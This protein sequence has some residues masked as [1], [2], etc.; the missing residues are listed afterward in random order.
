[1]KKKRLIYSLLGCAECFTLLFL[2]AYAAICLKEAGQIFWPIGALLFIIAVIGVLWGVLYYHWYVAPLRELQDI[3][4]DM[5]DPS[6]GRRQ[7]S[8]E[9]IADLLEMSRSVQ[10]QHEQVQNQL[11][12]SEQRYHLMA[13]LSDDV[14]FEFDL[15]NDT[16]CD[17]S[18]WSTLASGEQ[19][20]QGSI[21]KEVIHP[22]DAAVFFDFF[23]G[24][25][26]VGELK[27]IQL[28]IY[29]R[30]RETYEWMQIRGIVLA[31][32]DGNPGKI[33]GRRLN[34]DK[35]KRETDGLREMA[36]RDSST[37]LYNKLTAETRI[38][39][40]LN[41]EPE[42][43]C[44]LLLIDIDHFK[45]VNDTLGHQV[46]DE[47]IQ[48]IAQKLDT[49]FRKDDIIGR[50]GGDEY[51]VLLKGRTIF[52]RD[53]ICNCCKRIINV[54][55]HAEVGKKYDYPLSCSIGIALYPENGTEFETLFHMA[56]KA[57]Y[58]A[59]KLGRNRFEFY[60]EDQNFT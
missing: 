7:R 26:T 28:R 33:L 55:H 30:V 15:Q 59:K 3:F 20:V 16:I 6:G 43:S 57:L 1:M 29:S 44:V 53:G 39:Q 32:K 9:L 2:C 25:Q 45:K 46:G 8:P 22:D 58:S 21:S 40:V 52:P 36:Q 18:N 17:S 23:R 37:G 35:L 10:K 5:V 54:F 27:E 11:R 31:D 42:Q 50:F 48:E 51:I 34:I 41:G 24:P 60:H 13:K 56:D 38:R 49:L 4:S 19:F 47:V 14:I 12:F